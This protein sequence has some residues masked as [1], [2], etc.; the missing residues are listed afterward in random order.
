VEDNAQSV[1]VAA[2]A[3]FYQPA[4]QSHCDQTLTDGAAT[5]N[6]ETRITDLG[7]RCCR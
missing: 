1:P 5:M 6:P 7:F 3:A 4:D 2:G